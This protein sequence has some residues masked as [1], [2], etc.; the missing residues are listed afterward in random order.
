MTVNIRMARYVALMALMFSIDVSAQKDP[1]KVLFGFSAAS[2]KLNSQLKT[3]QTV[4]AIRSINI[5]RQVASLDNGQS[6]IFPLPDGNTIEITVVS[7]STLQNGDTLLKGSFGN[8]G[9]G[10]AII[11]FG[12]N[13]TFANISSAEHSYSISLDENQNTF[14]INNKL[15]SLEV[16]KSN[17]MVYP[18]N[19]EPMSHTRESAKNP[20]SKPTAKMNSG[21]SEVTLLFIYSNE[22][23]SGFA[24]PVTRIN[25]MIAFSNDAYVRSGINIELKLAHAQQLN[26][27]NSENIGTLLSQA[28][29]GTGSFSN[30]H[31]IRDQY[32][33]DMVAVLPFRSGGSIGGV[34]YVNGNSQSYAYSV[35]QFAPYGSDALF[36]HEVGHN[37]GSGH[38]RISA[39]SSQPD[40]CGGGYTGYACGHG[41]GSQGT[42]M[43]YLNDRAWDFVFSNPGLDCES[44]PCGIAQGSP[45]AADNKTSFNITGPLIEAFRVDTSND[46]DKDGVKNDVDNCPNVVNSNQLNTDGDLQGDA[47][48]NDDDNDGVNDNLD[49]CRLD[50]NA[51]QLDSNSNGVGDAC[52][53]GEVCFPIKSSAVKSA[54][55]CL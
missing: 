25:Q 22:F 26:F 5:N 48:D 27:N 16:D 42:I 11:T 17:D 28:R 40:P 51:D 54:V 1:G 24:N 18:P 32:Y 19:F 21:L 14:L 30:V 9:D 12:A 52:E 20:S 41:N 10:S 36:A 2:P 44:E 31:S 7:V 46:D 53:G 23:A 38:E 29:L 43:S 34:A 37:L 13:A 55:V 15:I 50:E 3:S 6:F 45:N 8:N 35:S 49:N 4:G 47:C 39:N 33:A